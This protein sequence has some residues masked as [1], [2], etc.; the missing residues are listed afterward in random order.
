MGVPLDPHAPVD[1]EPDRH[2]TGTSFDDPANV[3]FWWERGAQTAW[4]VVPLTIDTLDQYDLWESDFFKPF[5]PLA[6]LTGGDPAVARTS[7]SR[8]QSDARFGAAHRGE[9]L[10]RTAARRVMLSTAQSYRPGRLQRA[11]PRL[12]GHARRAGD[13][14]H[15]PPE[16]RAAVGHAVARRRR[17]LDRQRIAATRRAAR[18]GVDQPLR[19]GV[20]AARPAA[21]PRSATCDYTHAYFPQEHFDEVVQAGDWTFGRRGNGYV[22]LWSWRPTHWRT[23]ADP[24][25]FTH[26][27]TQPFDLVAD[28]GPDNVWIT[29]VG[30]AATFGSF[31]G[32]RAAGAPRRGARRGTAGHRGRAARRLRR[33][34]RSRRPKGR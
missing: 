26:G 16:E 10:S 23:Y 34:R 11:A 33:A 17:L 22:A 21:R 15:H 28:G 5:K 24:G 3:P 6:D 14:V 18:R 27:L 1:P 30:D 19:A 7:R 31:A 12:A 8:S 25:I 13:R 4:Q 2:R 20:R 9:H 32:F 29:Q